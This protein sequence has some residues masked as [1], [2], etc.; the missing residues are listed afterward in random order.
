MD[1]RI[2]VVGEKENEV[3]LKLSKEANDALIKAK[4]FFSVKQPLYNAILFA[5]NL[6]KNALGLFYEDSLVIVLDDSLLKFSYETVKNVFLH[7]LSHAIEYNI[8]GV[9]TGH[10]ERFKLIASVIGVDPGF[11]RATIKENL[12]KK[13]KAQDK[14]N[15]L[16]ALSSSSFEAEA[17]LALKMAEKLMSENP[18]EDKEEDEKIYIAPLLEKT[19]ISTADLCILNITEKVT[20][21]FAVKSKDNNRFTIR[22][23]GSLEQVELAI[24]LYD[25]LDGKIDEEITRLRRNGQ[26]VLKNA[27]TIG[28]CE[29]L[30]ST[31]APAG[32]A[33]SNA[34]VLKQNDNKRLAKK[35]IFNKTKLRNEKRYVNSVDKDSLDK[36]SAFGSKLDLP[37]NIKQRKLT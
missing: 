10:G 7:E 31:I 28:V 26:S 16:L 34:I 30:Y 21:V 37:N 35:L 11:D 1:R 18:I 17:E 3:V 14:I 2:E 33:A 29:K 12:K 8:F 15:K 13:E 22:I 4:C 9:T 6:T 36:G 5:P 23:Y 19:R 25:Y 24:Y 27:F 32:S 20:G